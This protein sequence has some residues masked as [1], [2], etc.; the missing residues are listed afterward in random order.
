MAKVILVVEVG[1][2]EVR[3]LTDNKRQ[4]EIVAKMLNR[5]GET[6]A[7]CLPRVKRF[8]AVIQNSGP[9]DPP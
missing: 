4:C 9:E 3:H 1:K 8:P 6:E 7:W 2:R 5:L